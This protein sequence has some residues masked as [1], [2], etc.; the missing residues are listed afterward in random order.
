M[1]YMAPTS[2]SQDITYTWD[3]CTSRTNRTNEACESR[4]TIANFI[5]KD[6]R[7]AK[8]TMLMVDANMFNEYN[9]GLVNYT[10]L[11]PIDI[12]VENSLGYDSREI[13]KRYTLPVKIP[14]ALFAQN[15]AAYYNTKTLS[16]KLFIEYIDGQVYIDREFRVVQGDIQTD[17]GIVHLIS[18]V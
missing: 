2:V 10:V 5:A 16:S 7:C 13:V 11:V 17:N 9:G 8:F 3:M 6:P 14:L 4:N 12:S 1:T 18:A 15:K